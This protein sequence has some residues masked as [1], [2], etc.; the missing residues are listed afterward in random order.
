MGPIGVLCVQRTLNNGKLAGFISGLGAAFA[1]TFFATIAGLGLSYIVNFF[2]K[3]QVYLMISG[4]MI[5]I[6]LGIKIFV[7]NTIRQFK[8]KQNK[9]SIASDFISVF[10]LTLSNPLTILF[11]GVVFAGLNLIDEN[12]ASSIYSVLLGIF[13][14]ALLWWFSLSSIV[15]LLKNRFR[16]RWLWWFNKVAG[17]IIIIFGI[18][19]SISVF[20]NPFS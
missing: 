16:L 6:G 7:T 13:S 14:G 10:F 17:A 12:D 5:L 4:G 3:Q 1:D 9:R 18:V 15:G 2:E 8:K 19:V 11:F 20:Y